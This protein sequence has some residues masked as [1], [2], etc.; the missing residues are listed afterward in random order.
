LPT[1]RQ[2]GEI[3]TENEIG[4]HNFPS[5]IIDAKRSLHHNYFK[6]IFP[7]EDHLEGDQDEVQDVNGR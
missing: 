6:K 4:V 5:P 2:F 3:K 7:T 1:D